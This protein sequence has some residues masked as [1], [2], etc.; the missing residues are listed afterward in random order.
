MSGYKGYGLALVVE[1]LSGVLAGAGLGPGVGSPL[2]T[3]GP[4]ANVGHFFMALDIEP[5]RSTEI[6]V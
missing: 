4:P 6:K 3:E 5:V 1:I 2:S